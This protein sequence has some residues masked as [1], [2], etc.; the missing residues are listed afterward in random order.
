MKFYKLLYL[1][2]PITTLILMSIPGAI[3]IVTYTGPYDSV[4]EI[5]SFFTYGITNYNYFPLLTILST[6]IL[7]FGL[8]LFLVIDKK[9]LLKLIRGIAL[10]PFIFALL[11]A[12]INFKELTYYGFFIALISLLEA[13]LLFPGSKNEF[14]E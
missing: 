1:I 5:Y 4:K 10:F 14:L 8:L 6:F 2:A 12:S 13:V 11:E 7:L 9:I 3:V